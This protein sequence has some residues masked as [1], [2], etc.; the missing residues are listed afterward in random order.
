M[1]ASKYLTCLVLCGMLY[2]EVGCSSN[3]QE[4]TLPIRVQAERV[5]LFNGDKAFA[6][7]GTIEAAKSTPLSFGVTGTVVRVLVDEG[8]F[9]KRGQLLAV[10]NDATMGNAF[11]MAKATL[12]RAEDAYKRLKSMYDNGNL[13]EIKFVEVET[14]LQQARAAAAI[15][16]KNLDDCRLYAS[17]DG[18]VGTRSIEPGQNVL[19]G[20]TAINILSIDKVYARV[21]VSEN[22]IAQIEKGR[23]VLITVSALGAVTFTG[24]IDEIGVLA[25]PIAHTYKV[26]IGLLNKDNAIKPGMICEARIS[27]S[28]AF[29]GI[30]VPNPAVRVDETGKTFVFSV[31]ETAGHVSRRYVE[32]GRLLDEG[33]EIRQGLNVGQLVVVAGQQKLVDKAAVQ[34]VN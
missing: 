32:T 16:Q 19:P 7:S 33:I 26:K 6:Y 27:T 30:I 28:N 18:Y 24:T 10:L 25:D 20:L 15:S 11:E 13:P 29:N 12:D 23:Q 8:D 5:Q 9:V 22:E 17:V 2:L 4:V 34:V 14:G 21:S 1:K 3:A 31:D